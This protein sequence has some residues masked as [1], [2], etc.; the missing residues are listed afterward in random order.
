M[1]NPVQR[2]SSSDP[3]SSPRCPSPRQHPRFLAFRGAAGSLRWLGRGRGPAGHWSGESAGHRRTSGLLHNLVERNISNLPCV[4]YVTSLPVFSNLALWMKR[5]CCLRF[6]ACSTRL[7]TPPDH[8]IIL[9]FIFRF[10]IYIYVRNSHLQIFLFI[11]LFL[12]YIFLQHLNTV[13]PMKH[14]VHPTSH[15]LPTYQRR[16]KK[17]SK[18]MS[19]SFSINLYILYVIKKKLHK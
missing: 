18:Q 12:H 10:F 8:Q 2:C 19:S 14:L 13:T 1:W 6:S 4:L 11:Y 3:S 5:K 16:E 15:M 17:K 7:L 9:S